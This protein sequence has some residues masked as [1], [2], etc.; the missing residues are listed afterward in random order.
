M[1]KTTPSPPGQRYVPAGSEKHKGPWLF[2]GSLLPRGKQHSPA[3]VPAVHR[4][5]SLPGTALISRI[6]FPPPWVGSSGGGAHLQSSVL[7]HNHHLD[8]SGKGAGGSQPLLH[9]LKESNGKIILFQ[10]LIP[11][12]FCKSL[13]VNSRLLLGLGMSLLSLRGSDLHG[14]PSLLLPSPAPRFG[15]Q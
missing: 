4:W 14:H 13:E 10:A 9:S 12:G 15:Q 11:A 8:L 3:E 1:A 5:A 6:T 2:H 7:I